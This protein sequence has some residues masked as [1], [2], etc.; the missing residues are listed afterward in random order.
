MR[1]PPPVPQIR[2]LLAN[3]PFAVVVSH[4]RPA[5][6]KPEMTSKTQNR[7][8]ANEMQPEHFRQ[9]VS[10]PPAPAPRTTR[11]APMPM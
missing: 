3:G 7:S 10:T 11:R 8:R 9:S 1:R 2:T 4:E 6:T 5:V